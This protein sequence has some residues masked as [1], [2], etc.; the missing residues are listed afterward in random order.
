MALPMPL[1]APVTSTRFIPSIWHNQLE[2]PHS[3][4]SPIPLNVL[5]KVSAASRHWIFHCTKEAFGCH[6]PSKSSRL[7]TGLYDLIPPTDRH[8]AAL[9]LNV[10]YRIFEKI[11]NFEKFYA[12]SFCI[13]MF[14]LHGFCFG[15]ALQA[16]TRSEVNRL[17]DLFGFVG[18]GEG[19][20]GGVSGNAAVGFVPIDCSPERGGSLRPRKPIKAHAVH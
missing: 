12:L 2:V 13:G 7:R 15:F 8:F 16:S 4:C 10:R 14:S 9:L 11:E 17:W 19:W 5:A 6:A 1:D 18:V 3:L 20:S